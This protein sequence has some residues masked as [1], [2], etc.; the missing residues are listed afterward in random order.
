V[1]L[2]IS[3]YDV[4]FPFKPYAS[5][6]VRAWHP[7]T[8]WCGETELSR[9]ISFWQTLPRINRNPSA[10]SNVPFAPTAILGTQPPPPPLI[11]AAIT[12]GSDE[13]GAQ[14]G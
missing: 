7:N 4:Q 11:H 6:L 3:G 14:G 5:Q 9:G 8:S 12:V 2:K 13:Q 10:S 1:Q